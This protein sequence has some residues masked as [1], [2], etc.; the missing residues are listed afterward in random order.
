MSLRAL[1]LVFHRSRTVRIGLWAGLGL[2]LGVSLA[3]GVALGP[4]PIPIAEVGRILVGEARD[5]ALA[6]IVWEVRLP[7]VLLIALAGAALA[8][9]GAAYQGL[10]RNP[11]ADP[12]LIG[13]AAG[14]NLGAL[15]A[16]ALNLSATAF[17][18][19]ALPMAAF[20]GGL[21]TVGL[22]YRL[23][24]IGGVVPLTTLLLAGVA[25]G[26]LLNAI[27]LGLL[28]A[29]VGRVA[30]HRAWIWMLGGYALGGWPALRGALPYI[31]IGLGL[32]LLL[33]RPLDVLQF[34]EEQALQ[35]GLPVERVKRLAIGAAT[36]A[37]A[38]AVAFTG[39][40]GF[41]GLIAPHL[42]RLIV[43]PR[44][45]RVLPAAIL[46]GAS[47]LTL[48]DLLS[49]TLLPPQEIPLTIL[50]AFLGGPFFLYLLGHTRR[51]VF[52]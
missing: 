47:L 8:G 5:P 51:G 16:V 45:P 32:L 46:L 13:V 18:L 11:L 36:L 48:A 6:A 24:R 29:M 27:S 4:V 23:A 12:Y 31:G 21:L 42:A 19:M 30:P 34:G 50:T 9:A 10:F 1:S 15:M 52:F 33:G 26:A 2:L 17:G 39:I 20:L 3:M 41:V 35:L 7:R 37:T 25:V 38:G 28:M 22:V 40:I 43:G 49:R 44:Y 14:A